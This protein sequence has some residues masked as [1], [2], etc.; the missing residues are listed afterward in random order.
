MNRQTKSVQHGVLIRENLDDALLR[1]DEIM[2]GLRAKCGGGRIVFEFFGPMAVGMGE[3]KQQ[4]IAAKVI[5]EHEQV[6]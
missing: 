5:S 4:V 6:A 3:N 1:K 2:S